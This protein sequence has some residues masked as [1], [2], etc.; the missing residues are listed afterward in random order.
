VAAAAESPQPVVPDYQGPN[1]RAIIPAL[2]GPNGTRDLP[3]WMPDAVTGARQV[4]VLVLDGLGWEQLAERRE[5]A[6]TLSAMHGG[7]ITSVVPTT[8]ATALT[9]ITTGLT[10]GEH[11]LIGY[12][13][14]VGGE[15]LN[16][17]QWTVDGADRRRS[18]PPADLQSVQAFLGHE[19][20]VVAPRH[21]EGSAFTQAHLRGARA[22]GWRAAS[23]I[24]VRIAELLAEGERLVYA[25]YAG[26]DTIAHEHGFGTYYDAELAIADDLVRRIIDALPAGAVLLVTSDHGQVHVGDNQVNPSPEVLSLVSM[27]SGEGRFR[28]LH[29]KPGAAD[30][31][32]ATS[33]EEFGRSAWV[34]DRER[35]VDEC[36]LGR[37]LRPAVMA[38]LGDVALV[39]HASV[40]FHDPADSGPYELICRHGSL[41]SAEVYVPLL[42]ASR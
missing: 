25:Y 1:I 37:T 4:A 31:L 32:M 17:L 29:A 30:E 27:Q 38:R 21:L 10:P 33:L 41:T 5:V 11:G 20:P 18:M 36:W 19:I 26:I 7:P 3:A 40:S 22:V 42:A 15:V 6:P 35:V 28:W 24:P 8:T 2:L 12:R 16:V 13:M 39:A 9:S 14:A 23:S 34:V